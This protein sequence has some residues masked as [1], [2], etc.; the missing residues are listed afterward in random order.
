MAVSSGSRPIGRSGAA[1]AAAISV[2]KCPSIRSMVG[3][4]NRSTLYSAVTG[5]TPLMSSTNSVRSNRV[6]TLAVM[7]TSFGVSTAFGELWYAMA[8]WKKRRAAH[9]ALRVEIG[10]QLFERDI[11]VAV[12]A[13]RGFAHARRAVPRNVGFPET[14]WRR[15][16]M[17]T[18]QPTSP[19]EQPVRAA[20]DRGA[21]EDVVL[22]GISVQQRVERREEHHERG[23]AR[24]HRRR[25]HRG[26][27]RSPAARATA[28]TRG[29]S[30]RPAAGDRSANR[31]PQAC[32][33]GGSRQ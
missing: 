14:S 5:N 4:S 31:E 20:G 10:H 19:F 13:E 15:T 26:A 32:R 17:L 16:S 1:R 18:K 12:R 8:T 21:E 24:A 29:A 11:G 23:D 22:P 25:P 6:P 3:R 9:V 33:R 2:S 28:T 27:E 7:L 30:V